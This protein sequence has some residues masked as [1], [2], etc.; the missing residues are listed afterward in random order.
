M[1]YTITQVIPKEDLLIYF[2]NQIESFQSKACVLS[3][4]H[5]D[6]HLSKEA[7]LELLRNVTSKTEAEC[8]AIS[9]CI[10]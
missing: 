5:E 10:D 4:Y 6:L 8:K 1:K 3:P 9:I 7:K 2:S